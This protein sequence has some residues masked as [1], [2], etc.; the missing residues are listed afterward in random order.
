LLAEIYAGGRA[1]F[2]KWFSSL[3]NGARAVVEDLAFGGN[4]IVESSGSDEMKLLK[5]PSATSMARKSPSNPA[6]TS[7]TSSPSSSPKK[8]VRDAVSEQL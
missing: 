1:I 5:H 6:G 4:F 3:E 8:K 2:N 7:S